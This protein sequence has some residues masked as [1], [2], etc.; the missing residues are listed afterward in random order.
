MKFRKNLVTIGRL[1]QFALDHSQE[2]IYPMPLNY[3]GAGRWYKT[4]YSI[5]YTRWWSHTISTQVSY[6]KFHHI[7]R[8]NEIN[9]GTLLELFFRER[10]LLVSWNLEEILKRNIPDLEK[11][12]FQPTIGIGGVNRYFGQEIRVWSGYF[13]G[14]FDFMTGTNFYNSWG[15]RLNFGMDAIL[16]N[17]ISIGADFGYTDYLQKKALTVTNPTPDD[18][19]ASN[20]YAP[21]N[22]IIRVVPRI[23]VVF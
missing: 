4:N 10:A 15:Y 2:F 20:S 1:E 5:S 7:A 17:R 21:I 23:G 13:P 3:Y 12:Q 22:K 16:Y 14:G 6:S 9:E 11:I 19:D 8:T 18:P